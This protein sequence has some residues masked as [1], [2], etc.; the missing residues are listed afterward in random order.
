M[1]KD[2][3]TKLSA[4]VICYLEM[5]A[6]SDATLG[7][8]VLG[9]PRP[10]GLYLRGY[11]IWLKNTSGT[12]WAGLLNMKILHTHNTSSDRL[13]TTAGPYDSPAY[14]K[15]SGKERN[16]RRSTATMIRAV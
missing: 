6:S 9:S 16:C 1:V 12:F 11:N 14:Y 8:G 15:K 10:G 7:D 3:Y 4:Y 13:H 5:S 2:I